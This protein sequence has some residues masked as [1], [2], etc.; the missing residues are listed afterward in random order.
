M[1]WRVPYF[2]L[3]LGPEEREAVL[4]VLDGKWLTM[5]PRIDSFE[6]A[7]SEALGLPVPAAGGKPHAV[8]VSNGTVALHLALAALGIGPGDEVIVP[9]LTF[10]ADANVVRQQHA[11]PVFADIISADEWT[12]DPEDIARKITPRTR[13]ILVVHY[14]GHP[15]R[16]DAI[17]E[18]ARRHGLK[19]VEDACHAPVVPLDGRMLGTIGDVGC[20]SFFSNKNM[21]TGE[22]GMA[23]SRDS[24]LV[25]QL[26]AMRS[27]GMTYS[28]YERFRGHA[29][30]YDVVE[31]GFN[32]RM[33]EIRAALGLEQLKKLQAGT[34]RRAELVRL[35]RAELARALPDLA[36]P[37]AKVDGPCG[38]HIMP[39]LLPADGP[40]RTTVMER[41]RAHGVQTSIHYRPIHTF[42]AYA[43][44]GQVLPRTDALAPYIL[45]LPL[46]AGMSDDQV[47][48]VVAALAEA[49]QS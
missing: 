24:D 40:D 20:F 7:F 41:L 8:A 33:D 17:M 19:V 42:T 36:Y 11:V 23:V 22:G 45:S 46:Y 26:R 28:S 35:Y 30:G 3:E 32:Y 29:F 5:G 14:G 21:T 47:R 37:F 38:W 6:V 4:A 2:D 18:L 13:A 39:V 16:M 1:K 31:T 49:L 15:C 44:P 43:D 10:V 12:I 27:H 48:F 25:T 34:E 9:S